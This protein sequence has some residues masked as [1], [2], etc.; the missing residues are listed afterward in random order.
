M[1]SDENVNG[2]MQNMN[3]L[4]QVRG[5]RTEVADALNDTGKRNEKEWNELKHGARL[6][7]PEWPISVAFRYVPVEH[8]AQVARLER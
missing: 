4:K 8:V 5:S 7:G 1:V 2:N 3:N 6:S